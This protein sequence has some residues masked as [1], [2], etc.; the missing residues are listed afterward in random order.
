MIAFNNI[1]A[2]LLASLPIAS[3]SGQKQT[4]EWRGTV[5]EVDGVIVVKNPGEPLIPEMKIVFKE[6]LL[7]RRRL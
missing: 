6:D 3:I 2:C 5:E 4:T 7:I 1:K